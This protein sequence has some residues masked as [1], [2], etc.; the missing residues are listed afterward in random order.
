MAATL[1]ASVP[2]QWTLPTAL[3][4]ARPG[5]LP[6]RRRLAIQNPFSQL[7]LTKD[8]ERNWA[9]LDMH[10]RKSEISLS[11]PVVDTRRGLATRVNPRQWSEER[12]KR[13]RRARFTLR[14][15]V[16]EFYRSVYTHS[17]EWALHTKPAAKAA[18]RSKTKTPALLGSTL[19]AA[20]RHGQD[21]QTKGIPIGPDTSL[22]LA[23]VVMCAID[24]E[25]QRDHPDVARFGVRFMDDLEFAALSRAE[26]EDVL[27]SW[28][29]RLSAFDLTLNPLKTAIY[30]GPLSPEESWQVQLKHFQIRE[31]TDQK[32]ANDIR[33]LFSLAFQLSR[34]NPTRSVLKYA[35][36]RCGAPW[37][38][39]SQ[40]G[41]QRY[42]V[43]LHCYGPQCGRSGAFCLQH[44]PDARVVD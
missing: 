31:D 41:V 11:R 22:L 6:L 20:V 35:L 12:M 10:L 37:G 21:G 2:S 18:M 19:D 8:C 36:R 16:S 13:T 7:L 43:V 26:A 28:D 38:A 24:A 1:T 4:L 42:G 29:S 27:M 34:E 9:D 23:E 30:D 40:A 15:D 5:T 3:N 32:Q 17:L 39:A 44:R 33:S 14:A 25:L